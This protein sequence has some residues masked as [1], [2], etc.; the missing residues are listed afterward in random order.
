MGVAVG[1]LLLAL[2]RYCQLQHSLP[3]LYLIVQSQQF[4]HQ[5]KKQ[6]NAGWVDRRTLSKVCSRFI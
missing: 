2:N 6:V 3:S 4:K 5:N 1:H